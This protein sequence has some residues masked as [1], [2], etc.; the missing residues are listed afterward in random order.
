MAT[1]SGEGK[2]EPRNYTQARFSRQHR[3]ANPAPKVSGFM[4]VEKS[5]GLFVHGP[6]LVTVPNVKSWSR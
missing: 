1:R 5:E 6:M 3:Q 2:K 4:K